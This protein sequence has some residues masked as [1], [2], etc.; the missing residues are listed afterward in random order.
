M[1]KLVRAVPRRVLRGLKAP[2][3][4]LLALALALVLVAVA[5]NAVPMPASRR[6]GNLE[7]ECSR[8]SNQSGCLRRHQLGRLQRRGWELR[9]LERKL[10]TRRTCMLCLI[11]PWPA[12]STRL[13]SG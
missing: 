8:Y 11:R 6:H 7:S 1:K 2:T 10:A 4:L 9:L 13:P 12:P 5:D 3:I